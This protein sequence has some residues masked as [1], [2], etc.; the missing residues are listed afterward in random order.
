MTNGD[1]SR[2]WAVSLQITISCH[3]DRL[4]ADWLPSI[5]PQGR[6]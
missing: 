4:G 3:A 2:M 6:P 5:R 1:V